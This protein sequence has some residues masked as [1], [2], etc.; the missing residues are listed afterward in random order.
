MN[1]EYLHF[2][3]SVPLAVGTSPL[4][5]K[6]RYFTTITIKL[7]CTKGQKGVSC[8]QGLGPESYH[9]H[10]VT[11]V[12]WAEMHREGGSGQRCMLTQATRCTG[13]ISLES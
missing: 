3:V 7:K 10:P 1:V 11:Q 9:D 2:S 6:N 8:S 12:V 5:I 13:S 4:E